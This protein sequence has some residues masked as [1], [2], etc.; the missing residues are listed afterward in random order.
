MILDTLPI[1]L[2]FLLCIGMI[3]LFIEIG[4]WLGR[5]SLKKGNLEKES[6]V[7]T[8]S[9]SILGLLAFILAFAFGFSNNRFDSRRQ[10]VLEEATILSTA[11]QRTE[12]LPDSARK[13]SQDLL[14]EYLTVRLRALATGDIDSFYK[15]LA[16]SR[17]IK[18]HLWGIAIQNAKLDL[19]SD[20]GALYVESI[21]ALTEVNIRRLTMGLMARIPSGIWL[22]LFALAIISM[23][24]VGYQSA[25]TQSGRSRITFL[26]AASFSLAL[27][28]IL[29]LDRPENKY[30][31]VSQRPLELVLEVM[32]SQK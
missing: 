26:L 5:M 12:M 10:L 23:I 4:L 20:I 22:S 8:I 21:N 7:S 32:N 16:E 13:A 28:I 29:I 27:T 3:V 9:G 31:T 6:Q 15:G 14:R 1:W 11:F 25:I 19:N 17:R 30:I 2:F 18:D 24:T